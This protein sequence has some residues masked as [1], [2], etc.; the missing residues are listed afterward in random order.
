[1]APA[2]SWSSVFALCAALCLSS[3]HADASA[4]LVR[5]GE[6][7]CF[8]GDSI[9]QFGNLPAGYVNMV[10]L[11]LEKAGVKAVKIPAGVSGD[12][13]SNMLARLERDALSKKPQWM[14][15]YCGVNDVWHRFGTSGRGCTLDEYMRNVREILDRAEAAGV[16]VVL[17]TPSMI[18]ENERDRRNLELVPYV[19]F[20]RSE[21]ARRALP[22]AD[23]SKALW[24]EVKNAPTRRGHVGSKVTADG[25]HMC[26]YGDRVIAREILRC[27]GVDAACAA[28]AAQHLRGIRN[29]RYWFSLPIDYGQRASLSGRAAARGLSL[30]DYAY[31]KMS[32]EIGPDGDGKAVAA[33]G[34]GAKHL[35]IGVSMDRFEELEDM[36]DAAGRPRGEYYLE[37][38]MK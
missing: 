18:S 31:G 6:A 2:A 13:S 37:M 26:W 16:K 23:V 8:L 11:G 24:H 19:E 21:A 5:D 9:T 15:L 29:G 28:V 17:L 10:M 3:A 4:P 30:E 35:R 22:L 33:P 36:A 12:T 25:V 1:M 32:G 7:I 20:V 14:T 38:L 34:E 27:L